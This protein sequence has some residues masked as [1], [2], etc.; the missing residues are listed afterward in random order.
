[1]AE[2]AQKIGEEAGKAAT[3]SAPGW[4]RTSMNISIKCEHRSLRL[5]FSNHLVFG[6]FIS[7]APEQNSGY[8]KQID[9]KYTSNIF[10]KILKRCINM[11]STTERISIPR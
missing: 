6:G 10:R 11:S 3:E 1:M 7:Q 8:T 4:I 9:V 5:N 2:I